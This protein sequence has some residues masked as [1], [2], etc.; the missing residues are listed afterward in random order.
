VVRRGVQLIVGCVALGVGVALLLT[1]ALGSDGFST[2]VNG[3]AIST[4]LPF[5]VANAIVSGAFV[6]MAWIRGV[7]PGA[8]T[9]VQILIV[10]EVVGLLLPVLDEPST[11]QGRALML[12]G[13]FPVLAVGIALYLGSHLGAGPVEAAGLAWDPP[14]PFAWTYSIAQG[15]GAV[16]GWQLGAAIGPGTVLVIF[17]LGPGVSLAGRLLG[18]D[19]HQS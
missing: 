1:P 15:G 6:A 19:L 3:L 5:V 10:G 7:I 4:G 12:A 17:L 13:A 18:Q 9:I 8:G 14:M 11:W 2:L 16:V